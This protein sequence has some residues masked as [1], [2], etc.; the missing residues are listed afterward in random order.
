MKAFLAILPLFFTIGCTSNNALS[1]AQKIQIL[2]MNAKTKT[3]EITCTQGCTAS[4]KDP[5]DQQVL[6]QETNGYDVAKQAI[7]T[8]GGIVTTV[9]PWAAVG[10]IAVQGI[11][12]AGDHTTGSNNTATTTTTTTTT[13]TDSTHTPTVVNQPAPVV[14]NQ[15][16]PITVT[17]PAPVIVNQPAPVVVTQPTPTIVDPVIVNQPPPTIVNPVVVDPVIV[18]QPTP[19]IVNPV[20]VDPVVVTP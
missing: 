12:K 14:V 1:P 5:R 15:P 13:S 9:A 3:F 20:V 10:A 7:S 19:T 11:N 6:P 18:N 17:Q 2:D 4:Y 8:V 16:A